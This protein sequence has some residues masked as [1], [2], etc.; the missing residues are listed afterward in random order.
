[1]YDI[2][3]NQLSGKYGAHSSEEYSKTIE[4]YPLTIE[5]GTVIVQ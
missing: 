2:R 3:E 4:E 1:M 5:M